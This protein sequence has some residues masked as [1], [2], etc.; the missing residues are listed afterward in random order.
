MCIAFTGAYKYYNK[1][2][3]ECSTINA[4][5]IDVLEQAVI[6]SS[7]IITVIVVVIIV[8]IIASL[9][10]EGRALNAQ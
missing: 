7:I 3:V 10:I 2:L 9:M 6:T 1:P 5:K 4:S 8:R